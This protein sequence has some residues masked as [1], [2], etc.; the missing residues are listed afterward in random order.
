MN[1][2]R[3]HG[4]SDDLIEFHGDV[5]GEV[6]CVG[7]DD[8]EQGVLLMCSDGTVLEVKYGKGGLAIWGV[9]LIRKGDLFD[10]IDPCTDEDADPYSDVAVFQPGLAWVNAATTWERVK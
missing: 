10:R 5:Y 1:G 3:I 4:R 7:T 6:G 9:T 2:T 8:R